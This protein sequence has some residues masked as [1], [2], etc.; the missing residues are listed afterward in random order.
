M[1]L[2]DT[3]LASGAPQRRRQCL[4]PA[5]ACRRAELGDATGVWHG[6]NRHPTTPACRPTSPLHPARLGRDILA[7]TSRHDCAGTGHGWGMAKS[8]TMRRRHSGGRRQAVIAAAATLV[9]G[10][11]VLATS[12]ALAETDIE[13]G[14][15][16]GRAGNHDDAVEAFT[17]AVN[18]GTLSLSDLVLAYTNLCIEQEARGQHEA[19]ISDCNSA[20]TLGATQ[21]PIFYNRALAHLALN[22]TQAGVADLE[23][24]VARDPS[25]AGAHYSL[26][27]LHLDAG[28]LDAAIASYTRAI[29]AAP[30]L[31]EAWHNRGFAHAQQSDFAAAM[32]DYLQCYDLGLQSDSV[33]F[34]IQDALTHLRLYRGD[35]NGVADA[36]FNA[37]LQAY[38]SRQ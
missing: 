22:H 29:E 7:P 25:L 5:S 28:E 9:A 33:I 6:G 26:G 15:A 27:N 12:P 13:Q 38:R 35:L 17:R 8:T 31:A 37:A 19:A 20:V 11:A 32:R 24:A 30:R 2:Q 14:Q 10:A 23:R 21:A 36:Q 16:A 18:S 1:P 3:D 4:T 34:N